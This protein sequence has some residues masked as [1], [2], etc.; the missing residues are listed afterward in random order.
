MN[1]IFTGNHIHLVKK[2]NLES[3]VILQREGKGLF[4]HVVALG[5]I[6]DI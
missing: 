2:H 6:P 1:Q 4:L 5:T 3:G